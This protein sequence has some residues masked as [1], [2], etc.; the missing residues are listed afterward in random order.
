MKFTVKA[1]SSYTD[2][3]A[4]H[5]QMFIKP[6]FYEDS[7]IASSVE[8]DKHTKKWVSDNNPSRIINDALSGPGEELGS[9]ISEEYDRFIDDCKFI[10]EQYGFTIIHSERS[11]TSN[12][13]EYILM[14]GMKNKPYGR[15]VFDFRISDHALKG[16]QFPGSFKEKAKE[17]LTMNHILDGTAQEQG[18]DFQVDKVLVGNVQNDTWN[19]AL[20][21][22]AARLKILKSKVQIATK[23]HTNGE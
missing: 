4:I 13:S 1:S 15:L 14:F 3:P 9:P 8:F 2:I 10:I 19:R 16:Q 23:L 5:I 22:L 6:I 11:D 18:I 21:R 12:R 17:Y 7:R 20:N